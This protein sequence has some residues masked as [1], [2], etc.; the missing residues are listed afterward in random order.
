MKWRFT[1]IKGKWS[2]ELSPE[3]EMIL[4]MTPKSLVSLGYDTSIGQWLDR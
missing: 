1:R 3:V 4:G 2:H